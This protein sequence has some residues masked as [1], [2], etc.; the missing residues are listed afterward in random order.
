VVKNIRV[1]YLPLKMIK[2]VLFDVDNV[3]YNSSH[4][5]EMARRAAV[6]AMLE[7]GL[8][9]S[10]GEAY[11]KLE[12]VVK[13]YGSNFDK[14]YDM[15]VGNR[16][17]KYKIVAAGM[18]AYHNTKR[19]YLKPYEDTMPTLTRLRESGYGTGVITDGLAIKQWE[20]LVRL[21]LQDMFDTVVVSQEAGVEKPD[22]AIFE[23]ACSNLG[24]KPEDCMYVGD[25]LDTDIIGA[26]KAGITSVRLLRGKYKDDKPQGLQDRPD[27]EIRRLEEILEILKSA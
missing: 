16:K 15:L 5:V 12:E 26:N 4:Q 21:G 1:L 3:L 18:V 27:F 14:H 25:R 7:S 23:K 2:S 24:T 8:G 19:G 17:D 10:L 22:T 11:G 13:R 9:M 20:K 6:Q